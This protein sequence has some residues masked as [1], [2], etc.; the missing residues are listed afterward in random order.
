MNQDLPPCTEVV[1]QTLVDDGFRTATATGGADYDDLEDVVKALQGDKS[2]QDELIRVWE[3]CRQRCDRCVKNISK[4]MA[5]IDAADGLTRAVSRAS[6]HTIDRS[7][8]NRPKLRRSTRAADNI[9]AFVMADIVET[10]KVVSAATSHGTK[11]YR[12]VL[13]DSYL[14]L[15]EKRFSLG[16]QENAIARRTSRGSCELTGRLERRGPHMSRKHACPAQ[17]FY[18]G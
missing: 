4:G 6:S 18:A 5:G 12:E 15:G 3:I 7:A 11:P 10:E 16:C 13:W 8:I 9:P 1:R 2:P 14:E 17:D